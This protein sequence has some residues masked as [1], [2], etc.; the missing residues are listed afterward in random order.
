[1]KPP[2]IWA[3][4]LPGCPDMKES[5]VVR[6][7]DTTTEDA[8][9]GGRVERKVLVTTYDRDVF[10]HARRDRVNWRGENFILDMIREDFGAIEVALTDRQAKAQMMA[11]A[12]FKV[13][14]LA[15]EEP[16]K[17]KRIVS[18]PVPWPN[19]KLAEVTDGRA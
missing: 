1:M 2:P 7:E 12:K 15:Y 6:V 16:P 3:K 11:P 4:A 13:T 17:P 5:Y 18:F 14:L 10:R 9:R 8:D 19:R